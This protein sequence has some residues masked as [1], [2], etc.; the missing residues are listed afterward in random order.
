M[1]A[2]LIKA[3]YLLL[4]GM[5]VVFSALV[6]LQLFVNGITLLDR[7]LGRL[8]GKQKETLPEPIMEEP[9]E[10]SSDIS[11]EELAVIAAAVSAAAGGPT[12]V[13][14]VKML[15]DGSQENWSRVGRL[16]IMSSHSP[17]QKK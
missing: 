15:R 14:H 7:G 2:N 12:V 10:E 1:L 11:G 5:G 9:E 13:H 17:A 3:L 4:I 16:D 6:A 8:F